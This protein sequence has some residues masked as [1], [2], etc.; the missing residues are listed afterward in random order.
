M[1]GHNNWQQTG[2]YNRSNQTSSNKAPIFVHYQK[3]IAIGFMEFVNRKNN[4]F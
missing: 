3:K 2:N 4:Y 1:F